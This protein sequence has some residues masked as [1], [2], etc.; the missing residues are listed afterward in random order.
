MTL[1]KQDNHYSLSKSLLNLSK[2]LEVPKWL[3]CQARRPSEEINHKIL[4]RFRKSNSLPLAFSSGHQGMLLKSQLLS[5][6]HKKLR[7]VRTTLA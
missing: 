1:L 4:N 6:L 3:L 5:Y 2:T 7:V